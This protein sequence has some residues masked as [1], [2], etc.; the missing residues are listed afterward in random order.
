MRCGFRGGGGEGNRIRVRCHVRRWRRRMN[1]CNKHSQQRETEIERKAY[2][3]GSETGNRQPGRDAAIAEGYVSEVWVVVE[4]KTPKL[5]RHCFPSTL[6]LP[7]LP[8]IFRV[9]LLY[10]FW[11]LSIITNYCQARLRLS[12]NIVLLF[13]SE[14]KFRIFRAPSMTASHRRTANKT[15]TTTVPLPSH[16]SPRVEVQSVKHR[17]LE[18]LAVWR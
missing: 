12:L 11:S 17:N 9:G 5:N 13:L 14:R 8:F 4:T 7:A 10:R 2:V 18:Y 16:F 1:G 3:H 6:L 15:T